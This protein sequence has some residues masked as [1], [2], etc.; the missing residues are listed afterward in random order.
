MIRSLSLSIARVAAL[1]LAAVALS[2]VGAQAAPPPGYTLVWSDEFN[3]PVGSYPNSA[4][5]TYDLGG[6]G[7][8]NN[9]Q[10]TYT[11]T[12]ATI[13]ADSAATDGYALDIASS[14]DG[15]HYY[16]SRIKTQGLHSWQYAYIECRAKV[17]PGGPS[18]QGYWPAFWT[19]GTD[20]STNGWPKCGEMD[21]MEHLCG[22][23]PDIA[24]QTI[25]GN[26]KGSNNAWGIGYAYTASSDLGQAYHLYAILWKQNS[27]TFYVDG[28]QNGPTITP[29]SLTRNE[30]WEF[31][32]P[33]FLL[34]NMAIG[35]N[36]PG[37]I[38]AQTVF[39]AHYLIDYVRVY[40]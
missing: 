28:V 9:E 17:P 16:S 18:Y 26:I 8:G 22:T 5:W 21:I 3:G 10:E 19:L 33:Q 1:A 14:T 25:H 29:S 35:G 13:V 36:W 4:N 23:E 38:T 40:Q 11:S 34:L 24:H 39:P 31:N 37:D 2:S 7:W 12:N 30:V 27:I 6:G 20:I 15:V 32:K